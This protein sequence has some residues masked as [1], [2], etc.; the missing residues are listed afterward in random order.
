MVLQ[1]KAGSVN[2]KRDERQ[3]TGQGAKLRMCVCVW[4]G[5][6]RIRSGKKPLILTPAEEERVWPPSPGLCA[7]PP[8][9]LHLWWFVYAWSRE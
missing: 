2:R 1:E 8:N 6:S 4:G 3:G 9:S 7:F 5:G